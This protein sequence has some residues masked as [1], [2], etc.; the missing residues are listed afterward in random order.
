MT[1]SASNPFWQM[2]DGV[3]VIN[4]EQRRDRWEQFQQNVQGIIPPE[5]LQRL[6]ARWG[7]D[8]PGFGQRPWFR[9]GKR[10]GTWAARAGCTESHRQAMLRAQAARWRTFL[11]IEDDAEFAPEFSSILPGLADALR[12][13]EWQICYFGFT[14]PW[15]P[16]RKLAS[17]S[18]R[19]NLFEVQGCTTTHGYLVRA[20]ARDWIARHLPEE[21][22]MWL[23]IARHRVIDR[24]YQRQLGLHFPVL[25]VSPAIINQA[26]GYSDIVERESP[27]TGEVTSR[28]AVTKVAASSATYYLHRALRRVTIRCGVAG[29]CIRGWTRRI[30]GF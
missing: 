4:L 15:T 5:K 10:D 22:Q 7:R 20:E 17:I 23:W 24:W 19:H 21:N 25:C 11:I 8:I 26:A 13:C 14:E 1:A 30:N 28:S 12:N 2:I 6:P 18:D 27:N 29:D 16:A 3:F 9:G